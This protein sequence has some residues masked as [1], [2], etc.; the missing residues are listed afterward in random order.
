MKH[1]INWIG[2]LILY[3]VILLITGC[4]SNSPKEKVSVKPIKPVF[5]QLK[6]SSW[7]TLTIRQKIGQTM[8]MLPDRKKELE[9]G[10]G[11]LKVYFQ[12]YPV[13][14]YF[15]GWKL[16]DNVKPED[17][18]D[19]I[20]KACKEYQ[21]ASTLPLIFQEDYES[22]VDIAGMTPFPNEMTLGAANSPELAYAYGKTIAQESRSVGVKWVLHPV[23]DLNLNSFNPLTNIRSISDDPDKAI[24]LLSQQIRGLQQ[25]GVAATIKHFPGDGVDYRD[26]HLLT[27]CNSLTLPAWKKYHGRVFK[28][29]IDSGVACIMPGHITLPAYQKEKTNGMCLPATLSKE[30][31][32]GLL[33]GEL[34]FKGVIVSDAM[35]M[36]GFRGWYDNQLEGEIHSF[37]AGVD[38]LLWP[39][40]AFMDTLEARI[41][42]GE[43]PMERLND[44]VKRVWTLK[45]RFGLLDKTRDLIRDMSTAEKEEALKTSIAICEKAV[46]L[47][48]DRKSALPLN[49]AKD[50]NILVVG[51]T[52]ITHV[53][54]DKH[55]KQI[56]DF[57]NQ[58]K[59]KGFH[60]D[61]RHNILYQ[62]QGWIDDAPQKYDRII[63]AIVRTPGSFG[64][65]QMYDDEAQSIWAVNAM[66][67][68]KIIVVNFG[69]PYLTNEYF[70][71]V[72][73]CINAYSNIPLMHS[74]VIAALM[75]EVKITG[76]SPV[77]LT[78]KNFS[79]R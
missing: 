74:A 1:K 10:N 25:S 55:L 69:S 4:Q 78:I 30:L 32:T 73:T 23:A 15:M 21:E 24:K 48:R 62:N 36:G 20:R 17:Y 67:K 50:K 53:A 54:G 7:K 45:E 70:E 33:K 14:G 71:R 68:D 75:G 42:R 12:N 63:I 65:L 13:S 34:G 29:L 60:V 35:V 77:D 44:A 6:D 61:F 79:E 38:V 47:L 58:L 76:Q 8:L 2:Q 66:P 5:Y 9:L 16:F 57:A 26:Q 52:P 72:S 64:P 40:Y 43:I 18:F 19:H 46:T 41:T 28:A 3:T 51:V 11:S 56:E 37:L 49:P 27:S 22:G 39:S 31:L 59:D